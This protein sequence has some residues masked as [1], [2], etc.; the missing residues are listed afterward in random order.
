MLEKNPDLVKY[1]VKPLEEID[2]KLAYEGLEFVRENI[3]NSDL[4]VL[5]EV[6][7]AIYFRLLKVEDV[8]VLLKKFPHK[9]FIIT[10]RNCPQEL[11]D[12]ADLITEMKEV[13]HPYQKGIKAKKGLDY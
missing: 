11:L 5:D 1:G 3:E 9:D 2:K 4:I 13:K 6:C 8:I 7:I 12:I 10:G